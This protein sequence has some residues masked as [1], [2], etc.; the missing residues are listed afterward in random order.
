MQVISSV[1][2]IE[3]FVI[4]HTLTKYTTGLEVYLASPRMTS[5]WK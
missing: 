1:G 2:S 3:Y 4:V 5:F